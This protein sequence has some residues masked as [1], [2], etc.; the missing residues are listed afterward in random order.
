MS[1]FYA[2]LPVLAEFAAIAQPERYAPLPADWHVATCDVVNST[3]AVQ[4]GDYKHVNTVGAA[5]VTA[6]LNAAGDIEIPFAFEGDGSTFCV[7]PEL[8]EATRAALVKTREVALASFGL[9][10]RVATLPVSRVREAGFDILVARYQ[11][12]ENYIQAVFAGG[13]M[14]WADRFMKDPA[15]AGLC[16]VDAGVAGAGS[17][18]GLECRWQD[19]PSRHGETVSLMVRAVSSDAELAGTI[20]RQLIARLRETYGSDEACHPITLP[21]LSAAFGSARL[22]NE[23]GF[24]AAERARFGRW[25]YIMR[26]RAVVLLGWFLMKLGLRT[27]ET[28]WSRYKETLARNSDVR[29]FND[30]YR[31]ILAGT[32][33]QRAALTSW[34][35]ERYRRRELVYGMH[36]TDRAHMTCLVFNYSGKHLH[37]IDGADGGLFLAAKDFKQR[38]ASLSRT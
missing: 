35:E 8:L 11:V 18:E 7:P 17:H 20:Y 23:A 27:E 37:F 14:S 24:R 30:T 9:E 36:V 12:S 16:A 3:A 21:A 13:G 15:T 19:V 32:A 10:L 28:D 22:G 2:D 4:A 38:A 6:V 25:R 34:L 33:A 1:R 26:T 5:A 31:Q 29:K